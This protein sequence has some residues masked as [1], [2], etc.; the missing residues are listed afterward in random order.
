[1]NKT[2]YIVSTYG[3]DIGVGLLDPETAEQDINLS[4]N[5]FNT[6]VT[7]NYYN[8]VLNFNALHSF[9]RFLINKY[10]LMYWQPN[11]TFS[12]ILRRASNKAREVLN[13]E[14]EYQNFMP[15]IYQRE[16]AQIHRYQVRLGE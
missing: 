12:Q 4:H 11:K 5:L 6:H 9:Y 16:I 2:K 8:G 10:Y 15:Q 14:T 3:R 7:N 13:N 1:M